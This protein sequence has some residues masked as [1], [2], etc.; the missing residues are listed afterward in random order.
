LDA[1]LLALSDNVVEAEAN[2]SLHGAA[3]FEVLGGVPQVDAESLPHPYKSNSVFQF[4]SLYMGLFVVNGKHSVFIMPLT[5]IVYTVIVLFAYEHSYQRVGTK[6]DAEIE[7]WLEFVLI[8]LT[9]IF[10]VVAKKMMERSQ[11]PLYLNL[12]HKK[13]EVIKEKVMRCRAEFKISHFE[14]IIHKTPEAWKF[15][16]RTTAV[17]DTPVQPPKAN[18]TFSCPPFIG[19]PSL[20]PTQ[21]KE[22]GGLGCTG[23]DCLPADTLVYVDGLTMPQPLCMVKPTQ[24]VLCYDDLAGSVSYV[25]VE[26][27]SIS[28]PNVQPD[29]GAVRVQLQDNTELQMTGNHPVKTYPTGSNSSDAV[30]ACVQGSGRCAQAADLQPGYDSLIVLKTTV[31]PVRKVEQ[32]ALEGASGV[33]RRWVTVAVQGPHRHMIFTATKG[34]QLA[35]CQMMAVGGSNLVPLHEEHPSQKHTFIHFNVG[36]DSEKASSRH[37][38]SAPPTFAATSMEAQGLVATEPAASGAMTIQLDDEVSNLSTIVSVLG[39]TDEVAEQTG[40][41]AT[42]VSLA[43]AALAARCGNRRRQQQRARRREGRATRATG[44][45]RVGSNEAEDN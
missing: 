39:D 2:E 36:D 9:A 11:R 22:R 1:L 40:L 28:E 23:C 10:V 18:S 44:D 13:E 12:E 26:R 38:V 45:D 42:F 14:K 19:I 15:G 43:A 37:T 33:D 27:V 17:K 32:V 35:P 31:V 8:A 7:L 29:R 6:R 41:K 3:M 34:S 24:R 16:G 20:Q 25:P 21:Q 5:I 30:G 4:H